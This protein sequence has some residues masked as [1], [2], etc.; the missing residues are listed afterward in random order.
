MEIIN[1][2]LK[3]FGITGDKYPYLVLAILLIAGGI[4]LKYSISKLLKNSEV[5]LNEIQKDTER[6]K[7]FIIAEETIT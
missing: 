4:Y 7:N 1:E 3:M 2:S 5:S 6:I